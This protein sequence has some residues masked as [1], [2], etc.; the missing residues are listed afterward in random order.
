MAE[1]LTSTSSGTPAFAQR[2]AWVFTKPMQ[3]DGRDLGPL[4][5]VENGPTEVPRIYGQAVRMSENK[6]LILVCSSE[7]HPFFH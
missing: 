5:A 2:L 3:R 6:I 1:A 4:D 7:G